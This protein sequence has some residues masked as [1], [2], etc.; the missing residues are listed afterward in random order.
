MSIPHNDLTRLL[1]YDPESGIWKRIS[2]G[3][4]IGSV[5][6]TRSGYVIIS[7]FGKC[8]RAH[9]LAWFYMTG[10]WPRQIDHRD[11]VRSN[12]KRTNLREASQ[13][14]N[15]AN[16]I[17]PNKSGYKGVTWCRSSKKWRAVIKINKKNKILGYKTTPEAAHALYC[18]A[19]KEHF[20]E[21]ARV[22]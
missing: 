12:N 7:L 10:R 1:H 8:Y 19:A 11:R 22:Q 6:G 13:S 5:D 21:F 9:R 4:R 18:A 17:R 15:N 2:N 14:Q 20:G 3:R 16:S